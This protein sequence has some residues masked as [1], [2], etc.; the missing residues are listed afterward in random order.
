MLGWAVVRA[1]Q[2]CLQLVSWQI[3]KQQ[4]LGPLRN[5]LVLPLAEHGQGPADVTMGPHC[6]GKS[7][8]GMRGGP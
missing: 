3:D 1:V 7:V 5:A 4:A 8:E 2:L 6:V